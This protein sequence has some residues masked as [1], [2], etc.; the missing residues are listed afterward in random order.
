MN[1]VKITVA[2][3]ELW[4]ALRT[5]E[6][7]A[8]GN[9]PP[10]LIISCQP[11]R[12]VL[13]VGGS[14]IMVNGDGFFPGQTRLSGTLV[15]SLKT[16]LLDTESVQIEQQADRIKIGNIGHACHWENPPA[17]AIHLPVNASL[18]QMLG[19]WQRFDDEIERSGYKPKFEAADQERK[20][21]IQKALDLLS[22][23]GV[24]EEDIIRLVDDAIVRYN[25]TNHPED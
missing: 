9:P 10:E 21:R 1:P 18:V 22:E 24:T 15:R 14:S 4:Q 8:R 12:L 2:R 11:N 20:T 3:I 13:T 17:R 7:A 16:T 23:L 25:R 5:L 19:I 6:V